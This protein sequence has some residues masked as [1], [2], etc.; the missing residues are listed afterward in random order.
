MEVGNESSQAKPSQ[1]K[2]QV[3]F[4]L[5]A[6]DYDA[7]VEAA[8]GRGESLAT[9]MRRLVRRYLAAIRADGTG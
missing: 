2:Q 6:A 1:A 3:H 4:R 7:M 8:R 5:N 9:I